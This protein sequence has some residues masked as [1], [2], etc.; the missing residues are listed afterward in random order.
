MHS[1]GCVVPRP[2]DRLVPSS[3]TVPE[4]TMALSSVGK[5]GDGDI[6]GCLV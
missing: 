1:K 5:F 2:S 3:S 4:Y 6:Q